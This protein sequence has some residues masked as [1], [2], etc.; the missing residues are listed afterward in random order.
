MRNLIAFCL[1]LLLLLPAVAA[2]AAIYSYKDDK[3]RTV[4]VDNEQSIPAKYR[5]ST[6]VLRE[7]RSQPAAAEGDGAA[8]AEPEGEV[9]VDRATQQQAREQA[10][11]LERK[12][13]SQTPV[14]VRGNRVMVP[15]EVVA[16][17]KTANLMLL[18]D[19]EIPTTLFHRASVA[20]LHFPPG[21]NA[22][23][24]LSGG[25]KLKAE[26][27]STQHI[28]IGPFILQDFPILLVNPQADGLAYDG[29][30]GMDFL[31]SHP[32]EINYDAE[33]IYWKTLP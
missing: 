13:A 22:D 27:V 17:G 23:I 12:R 3:G 31:E 32:Y 6:A 29:Q 5:G 21:T 19:P 8:P 18:L 15:V 30:L 24:R 20:G 14:M 1:T 2:D 33:M 9:Y 11:M 25:R 26:K 4:F 10:R 16:G 28:D 7:Q